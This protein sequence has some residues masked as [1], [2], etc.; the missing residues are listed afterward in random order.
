ML[1]FGEQEMQLSVCPCSPPGSWPTWLSG[2]IALNSR[3][4]QA[5]LEP[6]IALNS[7]ILEPSLEAHGVELPGGPYDSGNSAETQFPPREDM[8]DLGGS[9][10]VGFILAH[11]QPGSSRPRMQWAGCAPRKGVFKS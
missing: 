6:G 3:V 9:G 5:S 11:C 7:T 1:P 2:G 4:L 8:G 10:G